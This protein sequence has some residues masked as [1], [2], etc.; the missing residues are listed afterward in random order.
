MSAKSKLLVT[1]TSSVAMCVS[2][3][4]G[5]AGGRELLD[6]DGLPVFP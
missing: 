4:K 5:L 3:A 1:V 6:D 2:L